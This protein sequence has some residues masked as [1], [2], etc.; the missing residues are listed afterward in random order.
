MDR[1]AVVKVSIR[2]GLCCQFLDAP[3]RFRAA[4]HRYVWG[5][6]PAA[7]RE[8]L[9][10][11]ARDNAAALLASVGECR[12]LGIGAFRINSGILPL[13]THPA[14]GYRLPGIDPDGTTE[15]LFREAGEAARA[16]DL[17]LSFH[18]DQFVVLNS[19]REAVVASSVSELEYQAAVAKLVGADVIVFHGG[20]TAG[21]RDAAL[22]RLE[23][24]I[25]RLSERARVRA[26]LENDDRQYAPA[27][28]LPLCRRLGIPLVYDVHHHRCRPDGLSVEEATLAAAETWNGREPYSHISSPRDGWDAANPRPHADYVD[29]AD[30]P[31]AWRGVRMTVDVEAKDKERAVTAL[32]REIGSG[33]VVKPRGRK[34]GRKAGQTSGG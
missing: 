29:L 6:E 10:G 1:E 23:R 24:G 20:S 3:I 28:L 5:L 14:S 34:S 25:E 32:M 21:G 12:R 26:A 22:E 7:R 30:W 11:I 18:P 4:T 16:A 13:S 8:Y 2:Y 9:A 17:R 19:E 31:D 27:D 33:P 15:A